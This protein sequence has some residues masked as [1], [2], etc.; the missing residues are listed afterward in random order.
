[1]LDPDI[2]KKHTQI[3][4]TVGYRVIEFDSKEIESFSFFRIYSPFVIFFL[5]LI[6][7][8]LNTLYSLIEY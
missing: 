2:K 1:M 4:H 5:Y 6:M 3:K 7:H 8:A